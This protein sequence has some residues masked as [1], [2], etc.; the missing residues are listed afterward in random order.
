MYLRD[1]VGLKINKA[2]RTPEGFVLD[3]SM[4][5][6]VAY[7]EGDCCSQC[8]ITDMCFTE[9]LEG[10]IIKEIED[11]S[12]PA[13]AAQSGDDVVDVWGH[14]IHTDKGICTIGMRLDHNGYYGGSLHFSKQNNMDLSTLAK[15]EDFS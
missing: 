13:P 1:L 9:A 8:S 10:A 5:T 12:L 6:L 3:T 15:L 2:Y 14:R 11:M 7:P 4:G